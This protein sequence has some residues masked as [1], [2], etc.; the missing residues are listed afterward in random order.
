M[1]AMIHVWIGLRRTD[2]DIL[3]L[4]LVSVHDLNSCVR[5]HSR[6]RLLLNL[7]HLLVCVSRA[8]EIC[9]TTDLLHDAAGS[10][11]ADIGV[12]LE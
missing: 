10:S 3:L 6:L 7:D 4:L 1:S 9:S 5:R 8:V 11:I 2:I 12:A